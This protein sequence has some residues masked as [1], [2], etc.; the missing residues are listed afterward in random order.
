MVVGMV[1]VVGVILA[2]GRATRMGGVDKA[3]L[4]LGGATLLAR[5]AERLGPQ[6]ARLVLN[7]NGDPERFAP[8]R[9]PVI[10]D[11]IPD[12]P[13]PLAG[14]LAGL[15]QASAWGA[16]SIVTAAADT[17]FF[18]PDLVA[19]LQDSAA[20]SGAGIALAASRDAAGDI[21]LHPTFGLWPVALREELRRDILE[22]A[23]K[24]ASW[25][26]RH[27]SATAVFRSG[28]V[29]PFFNVNT[30]QDLARAQA[31]L[32]EGLAEQGR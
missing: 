19:R 29:D 22:G 12:H 31:L 6:C 21:R 25:A 23:R 13:G 28:A 17:P 7:A 20:A 27:G 4:P 2:G 24:V 5:V 11:S 30:P 3:L 8:H 26:Q 9:L 16:R 10:A 1:G 32:D 14:I 18:P 15:D